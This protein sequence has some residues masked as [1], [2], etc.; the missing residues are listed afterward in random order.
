M[1]GGQADDDVWLLYSKDGG[2]TWTQP[3]RV[4]DNTT[5]SRQFESWVAVD[6]YGRVHVAWTDYR[7]G[8]NN[9]TW[10]ARSAD[11][12]KGFEPNM[13]VTD[14]HG[15]GNTDF[16]GDY[17]GIAVSGADVL[18]VWQDTRRDSGDIYFSRAVGRGGTVVGAAR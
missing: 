8:G 18:V 7:D 13:Q 2:D 9:E 3:I 15:S 11:P 14:G 5:A 16:L 12:T 10:Y 17:K 4:N 1:P 6:K